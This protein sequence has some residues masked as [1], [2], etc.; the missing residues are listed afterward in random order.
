MNPEVLSAQAIVGALTDGYWRVSVIEETPSTQT[1]IRESN[2]T[3]GDVITAEYQSAGR[4]RLNRSFEA[5]KYSALLFSCYM[6]PEIQLANFG[7]IPLLA[8]LS[9]ANAINKLTN[10]NNF[11]CKWPND[12]LFNNKKVAGLLCETLGRGV[13]IGIGINVTTSVEELPV[14]HATSIALATGQNLNRNRLLAEI[15]RELNLN[16][17]GDKDLREYRKACQTIGLEI[18][19]ELPN[20]EVVEDV[21]NEVAEN[22]AL[23][24][25]SGREITVG[26][27]IHIASKLQQ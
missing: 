3:A 27:L 7:K 22:G 12:I 20:G 5:K 6:E 17:N 25:R 8:G 16:I 26:D 11:K 23:I 1:L 4:G 13:L 19:A 21:A 18:S 9:V 2:P 10:S 15:L 14:S 24:L